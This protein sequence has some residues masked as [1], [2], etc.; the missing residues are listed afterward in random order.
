MNI[1][2]QSSFCR[3]PLCSW[4]LH[5]CSQA[6]KYIGKIAFSF[7]D[8]DFFL[9]FRFGF[10]FI[11]FLCFLRFQ[12]QFSYISDMDHFFVPVYF[13]AAMPAGFIT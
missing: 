7:S 4:V 2:L 11:F 10:L 8:L 9:Y 3:L 1:D 5:H 6:R 13:S 12:V